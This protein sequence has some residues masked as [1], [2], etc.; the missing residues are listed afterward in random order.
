[1][2]TSEILINIMSYLF[3]VIYKVFKKNIYQ[4]V[5]IGGN[6]YERN[7]SASEQNK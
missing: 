1:M 3:D 6:N 2:T 7:R 4:Q 5:D